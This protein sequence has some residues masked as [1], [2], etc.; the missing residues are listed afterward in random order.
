M[1]KEEVYVGVDVA[2]AY[3]DVAWEKQARRVANDAAGTK[4]LVKWLKQIEGTVR[5]ICEASGGYERGVVKALQADGLKVSVV[6]AGQGSGFPAIEFS[7]FWHLRQEQ[8]CGTQAHAS[9]GSEFL[10]LV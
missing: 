7:Q 4:R 1:S 5:V 10:R 3:L 6:Q 8:G 9:D 2:K